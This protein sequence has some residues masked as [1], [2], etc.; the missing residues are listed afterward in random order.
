MITVHVAQHFQGVRLDRARL[1]KLVSAAC[2]RFGVSDAAVSIGVVGN[3]EI[4]ELNRRFLNR[5]GCTDVLSFDLS[6]DSEPAGT[7]VFDLIVNAELAAREA[8]RRGHSAR[9]ELA[10]YIVH[11]LLHNLGFDDA[12]A[13]QAGKMHDTEDEIL[14]ALGYGA[15][16]HSDRSAP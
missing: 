15:V 4:G 8:E 14:R 1:E 13:S 3:A 9:A 16:Y 5:D 11:G 7:R 6:D 12:T 10:L 2:G